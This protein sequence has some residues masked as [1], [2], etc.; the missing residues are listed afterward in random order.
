[1]NKDTIQFI[2]YGLV[3][4]LN[5]L[6]FTV[7]AFSFSFIFNYTVYTTIS[8]SLAILFSFFMNKKY[9]FE[10]A[11]NFKIYIINFFAVNVSLLIIVQILQIY[12]IEKV[13][14]RELFAIMAC[15]CVYTFSGFLLNKFFVFKK[16]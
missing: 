16:K 6:I 7:S 14:L 4:V 11:G 3:G 10:S 13:L 8:Y 12:L 2:K 5:T 9:T 1:M 15:M